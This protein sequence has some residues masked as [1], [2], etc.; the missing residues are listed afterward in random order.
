MPRRFAKTVIIVLSALIAYISIVSL[1]RAV[2]PSLFVWSEEDREDREWVATSTS[3]LDR[4]ICHFFGLCGI[5]HVR[6]SFPS[7]GHGKALNQQPID[8]G[9]DQ[10]WRLDWTVADGNLTDDAKFLGEIPEYVLEYAPLVHLFSG[11]EFWPGDIA[12]HLVYTT[13]QL[14]YTPVQATWKHP[15]LHDLN[16]L[17]RWEMG[18]NVFLT[19]NDNVEDRP[20][21]LGGEVNIPR[22]VPD[23]PE[24]E[25]PVDGPVHD[26][27]DDR[28]K[29]YDAG[30][31]AEKTG[32]R[33]DLETSEHSFHGDVTGELRKRYVGKPVQ[34]GRS[35]APAVLVLIDKGNDIVD[36]FWFYFYSYNLGNTVLNVRFGNHVGDWEHC[37]VRFYKGRPKALFLSAH[38]AGEAFSYE[39]IE[40]QGKRPIIYSATGTHA[41]YATPGIHEYVLP[42]GL[43]HDQTDRGP[44]WDPLFN[45]HFYT[46]NYLTDTLRPSNLSPLAPTEWFYFNGHWGDK[47][48][49][50]GDQRQYRFAGQY[51]YVNGPLGPRFKHLGRRKVCQG[52][53][54]KPCVIRNFIDEEKRAKRWSGVGAGEEPEDEELEA[55]MGRR[56]SAL[57]SDDSRRRAGLLDHTN[58]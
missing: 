47:F 43:L 16:E 42:W 48:Y 9:D 49:P 34:G 35:E 54:R 28:G 4:K 1:L 41:M 25:E 12:E 27:D 56:V 13:P 45:S 10:S 46:Y 50:L 15:S 52:S 24:P 58:F 5:A 30:D 53:Y 18:R 14:N 55:I 7:G 26:T 21:W 57:M 11:E 20:T 40:K 39:A 38:T 29:W 44:L 31:W 3:W 51:H 19:S 36:A 22:P 8:S 37:M 17:N 6:F 2:K 32:A 23:Q 33:I